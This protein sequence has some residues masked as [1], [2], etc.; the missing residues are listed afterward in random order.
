MWVYLLLLAVVFALLAL[1]VVYLVRV[2]H[3]LIKEKISNKSLSWLLSC[4]PLALFIPG[5][6][7]DLVNAIVVDI[8]LI[9]I[10]ALTKLVFVIFGKAT[11]SAFWV[12]VLGFTLDFSAYSSEIFRS[13][14]MAVSPGQVSKEP[15]SPLSTLP[16]RP[17][18]SESS[19][20]AIWNNSPSTKRPSKSSGS[21]PMIAPASSETRP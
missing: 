19:P 8:H 11:V 9:I 14:I 4:L 1:T 3:R 10:T 21:S 20:I 13:G 16:T 5:L 2:N 12:C 7:I 15:A 17:T 6:F 18:S